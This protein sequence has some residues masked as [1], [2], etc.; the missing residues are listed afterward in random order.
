MDEKEKDLEYIMNSIVNEVSDETMS[1]LLS[2][3]WHKYSKE[4]KAGAFI[5]YGILNPIFETIFTQAPSKDA[6]MTIVAMSLANFVD[7]TDYFQ[8]KKD[9][10]NG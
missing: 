10:S 3:D 8:T 7:V 1:F 5:S 4:A 6:A 2:R 9:D